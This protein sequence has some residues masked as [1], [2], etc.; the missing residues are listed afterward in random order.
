MLPTSRSLISLLLDDVFSFFFF[1]FSSTNLWFLI[2]MCSDMESCYLSCRTL[3]VSSHAFLAMRLL[4]ML[5]VHISC[6]ILTVYIVLY[7][8]HGITLL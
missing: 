5:S 3:K 2:T 7:A 1:F 8:E 6:Q 4:G